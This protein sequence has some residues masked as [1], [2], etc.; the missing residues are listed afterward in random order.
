MIFFH[1][2]T[3]GNCSTVFEVIHAFTVY[4]PSVLTADGCVMRDALKVSITVASNIISITALFT[5]TTIANKN[6][7]LD[8]WVVGGG[9][10]MG[11]R[12]RRLGHAGQFSKD[13]LP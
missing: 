5:T 10:G 11:W 4:S 6:K 7:S 2:F 13:P 9:W 12:G 8:D 3:F 1:R